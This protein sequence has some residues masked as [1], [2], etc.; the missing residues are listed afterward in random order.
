MSSLFNQS[1]KCSRLCSANHTT[2]GH[3]SFGRSIYLHFLLMSS[4]LPKPRTDRQNKKKEDK[5]Q[6][7][8]LVHML[9]KCFITFKKIVKVS[10]KAHMILVSFLCHS[11]SFFSSFSTNKLLN[12][13]VK[14]HACV[15]VCVCVVP[16]LVQSELTSA[17]S[18]SISWQFAL[19]LS[20]RERETECFLAG[21]STWLCLGRVK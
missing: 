10:V 1:Q 18:G 14:P 5:F 11:L 8:K 12:V 6:I 3:V 9:R 16:S 2:V 15:C 4:T 19:K 17:G 7:E 13:R 21:R 20:R